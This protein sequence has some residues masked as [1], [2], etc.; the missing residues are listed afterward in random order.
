MTTISNKDISY[1][2]ASKLIKKFINKE[3]S[4]QDQVA[5]GLI[6]DKAIDD[7]ILHQLELISNE[8]SNK[9]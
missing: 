6:E 8:L 2:K 1:S 3:I 5:E 9:E 7:D 4:R